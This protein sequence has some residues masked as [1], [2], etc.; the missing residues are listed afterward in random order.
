MADPDQN[1]EKERA[2]RMEDAIR[3]AQKTPHKPH[4]DIAGKGKKSPKP[5]KARIN[6][7]QG[8]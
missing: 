8:R 4:K 3:R 7:H 6:R 5:P 2:K 1:S